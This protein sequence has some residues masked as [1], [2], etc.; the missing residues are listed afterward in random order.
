MNF[1]TPAAGES[2]KAER[3]A[4]VKRLLSMYHRDMA[5]A[6]EG[7]GRLT[8]E[9]EENTRREIERLE[10]ELEELERGA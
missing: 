2:G 6:A 7:M 1:E 5:D 3:L 9:D 8:A 4:Q 10:K